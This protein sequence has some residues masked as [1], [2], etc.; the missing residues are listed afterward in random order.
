MIRTLQPDKSKKSSR[1]PKLRY[2]IMPDQEREKSD[3]PIPL[4]LSLI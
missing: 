1:I 2:F 4:P 3:F